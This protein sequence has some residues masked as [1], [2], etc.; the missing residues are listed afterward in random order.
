MSDAGTAEPRATAVRRLRRA[1]RY[2]W[3]LMPVLGCCVGAALTAMLVP[4]A[5]PSGEA[6]Q[7]GGLPEPVPAV[8]ASEDLGAFRA[9]RRWGMSLLDV[10][11][12]AEDRTAATE[13]NP[14]AVQAAIRFVGQTADAED[15]TVLLVFPDGGTLR[16]V[17]G[18][19][20]PDGRAL[21]AV[22]QKTVT[23]RGDEGEETLPLFPALP[24]ES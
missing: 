15:R 21:A 17:E 24:E 16:L 18:D 14:T 22:G 8:A 4:V 10:Q 3:P 2:R 12:N 6:G 20:L 7:R 19:T 1:L 5:A 11:A 23:L 13:S 9:S